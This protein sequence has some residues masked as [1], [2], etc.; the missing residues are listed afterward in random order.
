MASSSSD[1]GNH[2]HV[3]GSPGP[4]DVHETAPSNA[5][6]CIDERVPKVGMQFL[7]EEEAYSFYNKY[8]KAIGF[9]IRRGSQHKVKNSSAIQQR[10]FTCSRQGFRAEDK[11]EDSFSYSRPETRC[12]CEG[13]M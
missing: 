10:T 11:R 6:D 2:E 4:E 7:S 3:N 12:G 9:S 13:H 1:H 8:A 5:T